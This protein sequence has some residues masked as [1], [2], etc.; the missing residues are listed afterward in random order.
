MWT[1]WMFV[2]TQ[3]FLCLAVLML[4]TLSWL[5]VVHILFKRKVCLLVSFVRLAIKTLKRS[6]RSH[7]LITDQLKPHVHVCTASLALSWRCHM[8]LLP[9][10]SPLPAGSLIWICLQPRPG[11]DV[12]GSDQ[13]VLFQSMFR[14]GQINTNC[15]NTADT[16]CC[17]EYQY[18]HQ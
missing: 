11:T 5:S 9:P 1:D 6:R 3:A 18:K 12:S 2:F 7:E 17:S 15:I 10:P 14:G 16:Q 8:Y 4:H 13:C